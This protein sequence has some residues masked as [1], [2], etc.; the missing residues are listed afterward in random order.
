MVIIDDLA[1]KLIY[2][3]LPKTAS[4]SLSYLLSCYSA[5][6]HEYD[7]ENACRVI[8]QYDQSDSDPRLVDYFRN[9]AQK[10]AGHDIATFLHQ[11][12]F[13]LLDDVFPASKFL[14]VAREPDQWTASFLAMI[15]DY[16]SRVKLSQTTIDFRFFRDYA[17]KI[18][19]SLSFLGFYH[20]VASKKYRDRII[21]EFLEYWINWFSKIHK[22][23][24]DKQVFIYTDICR[25][26]HDI[27]VSHQRLNG[28]NPLDFCPSLRNVWINKCPKH[29]AEFKQLVLADIHDMPLFFQALE[30][31]QSLEH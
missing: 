20:Q 11:L 4:S 29:Y 19:P 26:Q 8:W 28:D 12:N 6:E 13:N 30:L 7:H 27:V 9:R 22:L 5:S 21:H 2:L 23:S 17:S 1:E 31:F 25:L 14:A 18:S 3:G 15:L 10:F 16:S 24:L